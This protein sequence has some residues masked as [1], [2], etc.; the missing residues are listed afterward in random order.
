MNGPTMIY[1]DNQSAI[2]IA[3][4]EKFSEQTKHF[5]VGHHFIHKRLEDGTVSL[6]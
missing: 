5:E 1:I 3:W 2:A 4:N 6:E